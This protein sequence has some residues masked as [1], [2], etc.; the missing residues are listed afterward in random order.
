MSLEHQMTFEELRDLTIRRGPDSSGSMESCRAMRARHR[1]EMTAQE[2][3]E[4]ET[5][6]REFGAELRWAMERQ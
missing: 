5:R 4:A 6:L 1:G 2:V 3:D